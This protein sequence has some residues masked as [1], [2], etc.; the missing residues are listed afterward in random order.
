MHVLEIRLFLVY[1]QKL[2][3][4]PLFQ[5]EFKVINISFHLFGQ[6]AEKLRFKGMSLEKALMSH[7]TSH[8]YRLLNRFKL[9]KVIKS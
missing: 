7:K 1:R 2:E 9:A 6:V 3:F 8:E 4:I 5:F